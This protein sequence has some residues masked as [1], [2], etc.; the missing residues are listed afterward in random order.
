MVHIDKDGYGVGFATMGRHSLDKEKLN[1]IRAELK[2]FLDKN[3]IP[4][5]QPRADL[6]AVLSSKYPMLS[7]AEATYVVLGFIE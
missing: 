7:V 1:K 3:K 5:P 4:S 2:E 6:I